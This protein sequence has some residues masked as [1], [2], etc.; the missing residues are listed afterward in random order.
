MFCPGRGVRP[1]AADYPEQRSD[2]N[3]PGTAYNCLCG[4]SF[5]DD[6]HF[7]HPYYS[8]QRPLP[9]AL[10]YLLSRNVSALTSASCPPP[11][12]LPLAFQVRK[13]EEEKRNTSNENMNCYGAACAGHQPRHGG[14]PGHPRAPHPHL[15]RLS[16]T[17][18]QPPSGMAAKGGM[19]AVLDRGWCRS[20]FS[21]QS[22]AQ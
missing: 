5:G 17:N 9:S 2:G 22:V 16:R 12:V 18:S 8:L 1:E 13:K 20:E 15:A 4:F 10:L 7:A 11:T 3:I 19:R 14:L 21:F 6:C